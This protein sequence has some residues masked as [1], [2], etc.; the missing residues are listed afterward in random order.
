MDREVKQTQAKSYPQS[1]KLLETR[2]RGPEFTWERKTSLEA[3]SALIHRTRKRRVM[4]DRST[5]GLR[6]Q[7]IMDNL[8]RM[9]TSN[10][11]SNELGLIE[12]QGFKVGQKAIVNPSVNTEFAVLYFSWAFCCPTF[13]RYLEIRVGQEMKSL[14]VSLGELNGAK[15]ERSG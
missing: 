2:E 6:L 11:L 12:F 14:A 5:G 10:V 3:I 13:T 4:R 1:L 9:Y 8:C 15:I 7:D